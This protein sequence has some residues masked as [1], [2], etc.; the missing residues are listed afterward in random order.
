MNTLKM[1]AIFAENKPGQTARITGI[2]AN[3]QI[4]IRNMTLAS[5]GAFGVMKLLVN[6][7]EV[8]CQALRHDG[9]PV[10]MLDVLAVEV[11]DKVGALH[12]IAD[13]LAKNG[14]NLENMSGFVVNGRAILVIEVPNAAKAGEVL[15]KQGLRV[16][17]QKEAIA[18]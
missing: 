14:I 15:Q 11:P 3:A 5:T 4:N 16:L 10:T 17:T 2:L 9:F 1:V 8:A 18:L 7:P 6:D 13:C 12:T